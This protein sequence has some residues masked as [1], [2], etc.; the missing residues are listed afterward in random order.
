MSVLNNED[1]DLNSIFEYF[2]TIHDFVIDGEVKFGCF[3]H[4]SSVEL[5]PHDLDVESKIASC[6]EYHRGSFKNSLKNS[7]LNGQIDQNIDIDEMSDF[8]LV[9]FV[10]ILVLAKS[11]LASAI[12]DN[13]IN[14]TL[15]PLRK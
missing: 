11:S 14:F 1:S 12:V 5:G 13:A 8:L 10:G 7:K 9:N 3:F 15:A 2:D 6:I 4:N